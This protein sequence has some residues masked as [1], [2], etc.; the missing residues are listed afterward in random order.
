MALNNIQPDEKDTALAIDK[1]WLGSAEIYLNNNNPV[2]FYTE[3]NTGFKTYLAHILKIKTQQLDTNTIIVYLNKE[4]IPENITQ[5]T[6]RILKDIQYQLYTP[7]PDY[8]Q[9]QHL[10]DNTKKTIEDIDGFIHP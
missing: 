10:F 8:D 6:Q 7:E 3:L 5:Q 4:N 2:K 1:N 9:Q